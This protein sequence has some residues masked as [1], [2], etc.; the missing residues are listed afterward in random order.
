MLQ[1][2]EVARD[3]SE[4]HR[5]NEDALGRKAGSGGPARP[6]RTDAVTAT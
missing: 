4:E 1:L 5:D 6:S 2:K 3:D